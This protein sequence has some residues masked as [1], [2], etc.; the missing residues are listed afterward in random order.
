MAKKTSSTFT[1]LYS[2][3]P[4]K[5]RPRRA[6]KVVSTLLNSAGSVISSRGR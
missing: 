2:P 6:R 1:T 3:T 4:S 5:S